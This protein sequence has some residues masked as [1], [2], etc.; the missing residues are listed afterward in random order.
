VF[1]G[2]L[3]T[4]YNGLPHFGADYIPRPKVSLHFGEEL[5]PAKKLFFF[6]RKERFFFNRKE[7]F[8]FNRKERFCF[9]RKE[10]FCFNRKERFYFNRKERKE[11]CKVLFFNIC[12]L[13]PLRNPSRPLRL[14]KTY[15]LRLKKTY[16]LRLRA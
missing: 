1:C 14:K 2:R 6:N 5:R 15:P 10:R 8:Y 7:R 16:P 12:S 13:Y 3:H 11:L 9:N 4:P